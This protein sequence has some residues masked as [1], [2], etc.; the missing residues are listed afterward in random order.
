[1]ANQ[2]SVTLN[3]PWW[4]RPMS[5]RRGVQLGIG[6]LAGGSFL[7]LFCLVR[8]ARAADPA[9]R[10]ARFTKVIRGHRD[11]LDQAVLDDHGDVRGL[12]EQ[13]RDGLRV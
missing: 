2:D 4:A 13:A 3:S 10:K 9:G 6:G 5:R 11:V 12:L 1:M 7:D 8:E